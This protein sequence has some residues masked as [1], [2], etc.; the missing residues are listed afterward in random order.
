[1]ND[2]PEPGPDFE[3]VL[4]L[5]RELEAESDRGAVLVASA[6]LEEELR[7]LLLAYFVESVAAPNTLFDGANAPLSSF[8]AKIDVAYRTGRVS[9]RFCRDLHV[10]RRIRNDVAH[11]PSGCTFEDPSLLDRVLALTKSHGL[12]E[13]SPKW[14]AR[15]GMPSVRSQFA[16]AASWMIFFLAAERA[17]APRLPARDREFGYRMSMD[18]E[19]LED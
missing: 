7:G 10:I 1:M 4:R 8:S 15:V 9:D 6:M 17:R 16:E 3:A 12:Y 11:R 14:A 5:Q 19:R 13:R 18:H 2:A